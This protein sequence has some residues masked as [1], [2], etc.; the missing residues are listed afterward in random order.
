MAQP[1]RQKRA[2]REQLRLVEEAHR[3]GPVGY[4]EL[5]EDRGHVAADGRGRD[6]QTLRDLGGAEALVHQLED[7][8][9]AARE[10]SRLVPPEQD[11]SLPTAL[12]LLD[13]PRHEGAGQG[14]FAL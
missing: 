6:E 1:G 8:P 4:A 10:A 11:T 7:F 14:G 9:L 12:E 2:S 13:D 5:P 3:R